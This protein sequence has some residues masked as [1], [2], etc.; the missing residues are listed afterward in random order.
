LFSQAQAENYGW[1]LAVVAAKNSEKPEEA[2]VF[3]TIGET[4]E[5]LYLQVAEQMREIPAH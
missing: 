3:S 1:H 5:R 4:M 2:R